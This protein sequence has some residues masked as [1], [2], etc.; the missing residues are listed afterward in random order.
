MGQRP[1]IALV[2]R[3]LP[4]SVIGIDPDSYHVPAVELNER[5]ELVDVYRFPRRRNCTSRK[6]EGTDCYH[7]RYSDRLHNLLSAE[8]SLRSNA[9]TIV[10]EDVYRGIGGYKQ[11]ESLC[12]VKHEI[13]YV[14]HTVGRVEIVFVKPSV[15]MGALFGVTRPRNAV[16]QLYE[17]RGRQL[18]GDSLDTEHL[19]AA[20]CIAEYGWLK[21]KEAYDDER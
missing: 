1:W 19:C 7:R 8:K 2:A 12:R 20:A 5:L 17:R 3:G 4:D 9:T 21:L 18:G 10:V 16:R 6:F 13:Q 14:A 11:F 15:W